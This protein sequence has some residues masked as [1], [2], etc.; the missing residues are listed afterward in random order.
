MR[1]LLIVIFAAF[2]AIGC[3]NKESKK[4]NTDQMEITEESMKRVLDAFNRHDLDAIME[5]FTEDC[6]FDFPRGPEPY[7]Q[8]FVG[9]AQVREGLA[10][11]FKGIPDVHYGDD[12]HWISA[13]GS[14]GV[15]EW[16]LTGTTTAGIQLK[17]RG[18]D[19]W[20]FQDGRIT[21]KDSYWKIVEPPVNR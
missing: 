17:V 19:L 1:K 21:R 7:G 9:K 13:D 14:K 12:R 4:T 6:S 8:R 18:C 5:Y 2:A 15:S 16:L 10:G 11:R 20:E 3:M